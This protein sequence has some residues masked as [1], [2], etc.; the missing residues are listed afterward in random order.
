MERDCCKFICGAPTTFQGYG[1]EKNRK[2]INDVTKSTNVIQS[3]LLISKSTGPSE[4]LRDMRTS[5]YQ[6]C[7]IEENTN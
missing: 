7:R 2:N 4:T 5:T 6:I 3:T 1:I